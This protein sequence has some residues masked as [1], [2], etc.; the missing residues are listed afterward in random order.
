MY[1][2][3]DHRSNEIDE[4][5]LQDEKHPEQRISTDRGIVIEISDNDEHV[6]DSIRVTRESFA[7]EIDESDLQDE[8]HPE[9]RI[10]TDRGILMGLTGTAREHEPQSTGRRTDHFEWET[11]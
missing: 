10:S 9:Q 2:N 8:K 1:C 6:L 5:D 3:I 4:N 11:A 7:N